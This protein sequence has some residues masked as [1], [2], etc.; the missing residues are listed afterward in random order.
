MS[1][2]FWSGLMCSNADCNKM[3]FI[4]EAVGFLGIPIMIGVWCCCNWSRW[5]AIEEER[6]KK[7]EALIAK[8][9]V[10]Y[11][12]VDRAPPSYGT[13]DIGQELDDHSNPPGMFSSIVE[14][15][16][17]GELGGRNLKNVPDF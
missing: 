5:Q 13:L 2:L 11:D 3:V 17:S 7:R 14:L 15:H 6:E 8:T 1:G 4:A 12:P 10:A 16:R 9:R